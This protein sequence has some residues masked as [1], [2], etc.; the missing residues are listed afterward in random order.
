LSEL[1]AETQPGQLSELYRRTEHVC[2]E[3]EESAVAG[4]K[5]YKQ[6]LDEAVQQSETE[7][8]AR[9]ASEEKKHSQSGHKSRGPKVEAKLPPYLVDDK[10]GSGF[11]SKTTKSSGQE[12]N[13][14]SRAEKRRDKASEEESE[15]TRWR[16]REYKIF[17]RLEGLVA[18]SSQARSHTLDRAGASHEGE[19]AGLRARPKTKTREEILPPAPDTST[20]RGTATLSRLEDEATGHVNPVVRRYMQSPFVTAAAEFEEE[21]KEA[22]AKRAAA[23]AKAK[24]R[25]QAKRRGNQL[26]SSTSGEEEQ[27]QDTHYGAV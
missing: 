26:D 5:A 12:A 17:V 13:L 4:Y 27:E 9:A 20:P 22:E 3:V 25:R 1:V 21:E 7:L 2:R 6:S 14:P 18:A 8:E 23:R 15:N 11:L 10:R 24:A 16:E 19:F